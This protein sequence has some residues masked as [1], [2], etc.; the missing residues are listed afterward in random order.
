LA[1]FWLPALA[2][3]P[4][5][6][7]RIEFTLADSSCHIMMPQ[8]SKLRHAPGCVQIWHPQSTRLVKFLQL[9]AQGAPAAAPNEAILR[10]GARIA[11]SLDYDIGGGS[12]GSEAELKGSLELNGRMLALTCRDQGEWGTAK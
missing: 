2:Q 3:L 10:N 4:G 6:L 12:G 5:E 8:G 9:C 11:Y 1:A 7:E